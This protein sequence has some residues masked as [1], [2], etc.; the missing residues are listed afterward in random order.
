LFVCRASPV[1]GIKIAVPI[2]LAQHKEHQR[3]G[4]NG[5]GNG[6]DFAALAY[7]YWSKNRCT[8]ETEI[9]LIQGIG[10]LY[11]KKMSSA[12]VRG[13]QPTIGTIFDPPYCSFHWTLPVTFYSINLKKKQFCT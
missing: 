11:D 3:I 12:T 9:C 5:N 1:S 4:G 13:Q 7:A 6:N 10:L 8:G 2:V